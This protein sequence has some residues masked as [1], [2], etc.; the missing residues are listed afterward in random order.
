MP[1]STSP[2]EIISPQDRWIP[3]K[4]INKKE[5]NQILPPLVSKI[6]QKVFEW[7]KNDYPNI[8]KTSKALINWWFLTEHENFRYYFAQREAVETVI[9]LYEVAN[10]RDKDQ[11]FNNYNSFSDV[12]LKHFSENWLR[13]VTKMATGSGKTKVMSLLLVWSYFNRT[14]ENNNELSS[15]FL[16]IAPN[17]IVLDR[18]KTDFDNLLIFRNDPCIPD[19]GIENQNWK[20]DFFSNVDVHIQKQVRVKKKTGNIFLTNIQKIYIGTEEAPNLNDEDTTEFFFGKKVKSKLENEVDLLK[21]IKQVDEIIIINDEA[22]HINDEDQAWY[23]TIKNIHNNLFQRN[24]RLSLQ[25]DFTATPK[26]KD[27][28][29]FVQTISDY[30]LTEAIHQNIVKTIE[31]PKKLY[32]DKLEINPSS[33]FSEKWRDFIDLGVTEWRKSYEYHYKS[34]KKA[35]L[36]IMTDDTTN[37]DDVTKFLE[38]Y[39]DDLKGQVLTIHTNKQGEIIESA[40]Q[41]KTK[42]GKDE[43][44]FLRENANDV[45]SFDNPYK[46]IVSVLMLKEGWDVNNVTTIVG[47]RPFAKPKILPEQTL[48]RGLRKMYRQENLKERLTV[49]G[50][51]NFMEFASELEKEGV[52]IREIDVGEDVIN[53]FFISSE[54]TEEQ[55]TIDKFD[56]EFPF[57]VEN[58][59]RNEELLKTVDPSKFKFTPVEYKNLDLIKKIKLVWEYTVSKEISRESEYQKSYSLDVY[60]I[61][62]ALAK[63]IMDEL[64]IKKGLGF[65][66]ICE[67]TQQFIENFFFG[68]KIEFTDDLTKA[69][70]CVIETRRVLIMIMVEEIKK[71]IVNE[72]SET[73]VGRILKFSEDKNRRIKNIDDVIYFEPEKSVYSRH[74]FDSKFEEEV[75]IYLE[76]LPDVKACIKNMGFIK[77]PYQNS[78]GIWSSYIP[79]FFIKLSDSEYCVLETKG[80]EY[81]N[82]PIKKNALESAIKK[83]NENQ[84]EKKFTNLYVLQDKFDKLPN[85]PSTFKTFFE[86]F[87]EIDIN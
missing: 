38:T 11:L 6:R 13:L 23:G 76:K 71:V 65:K 54:V 3:T 8:S 17:I 64:K 1:L 25:L 9:Y 83:I 51:P 24:S 79:D 39:Y 78:N 68:K 40:G 84:K 57:I 30:P 2:Y 26:H 43:L 33:K 56:I 66:T 77:I 34:K 80:A 85:K 15:N 14:Y 82:D 45:D 42:A 60:N 53:D 69:N 19:D 35:I 12:T 20:M 63:D 41:I 62:S 18:L 49:I 67:K 87:K 21:I 28:S 73:R 48:G 61:L 50:T 5:L 72:K 31:V 37:C 81:L 36:F 7:R 16:I 70:L 44:N 29:I 47:L 22:H 59:F 32:R 10:I 27:S 75:N 86:M 4:D 46:V 52:E 55:E 58:I 74:F